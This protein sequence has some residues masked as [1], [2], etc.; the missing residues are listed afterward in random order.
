LD[1]KKIWRGGRFGQMDGSFAMC[2]DS[3]LG[4]RL[5][6]IWNEARFSRE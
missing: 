4:K 2:D 1:D 5:C 6:W 3:G